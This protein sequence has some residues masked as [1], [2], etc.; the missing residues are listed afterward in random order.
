M[1]AE[2]EYGYGNT[3]YIGNGQYQPIGAPINRESPRPRV[4]T[5][6]ASRV[7]PLQSF[8]GFS[9]VDVGIDLSMFRC[10]TLG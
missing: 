5:S 1:K 2:E 6:C 7:S 10:G 3:Q 9:R 8:H 4:P